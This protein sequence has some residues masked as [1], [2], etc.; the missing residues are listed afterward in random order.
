MQVQLIVTNRSRRGEI[1][2]VNVPEFRIGRAEDCH[3]RLDSSWVSPLHCVIQSDNDTVTIQDSSGK[4]GTFV[5]SGRISSSQELKDGDKIRIGELSFVVSIGADADQP[6]TTVKP[7]GMESEQEFESI[8]EI[9]RNH[10]IVSLTKSQLF[11]LAQAGEVLPDDVVTVGGTKA[12]AD[13][14]SGIVFGSGSS[15]VA[16]P[17]VSE[18]QKSE[19]FESYPLEKKGIGVPF[20][21]TSKSRHQSQRKTE[22]NSVEESSPFD[23]AAEPC[24][25]IDRVP[26][27]NLEITYTK[28]RRSLYEPLSQAST[29]FDETTSH[30]IKIGG[31]VFAVLFLLGIVIWLVSGGGSEHRAVPIAGTVTL[32]GMPVHMVNVTLYPRAEDGLVAGGMT[33]RNGRFRVRTGNDTRHFGAVPGEYDV[34]F[35]GNGVPGKYGGTETSGQFLVVEMNGNRT[36]EFNLDSEPAIMLPRPQPALPPSTPPRL[37]PVLPELTQGTATRERQQLPY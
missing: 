18:T 8:F 23:I 4:K 15:A 27:A 13:S 36:F 2:P 14:I 9:R 17:T 25:Q 20:A 11:E 12:F 7:S 30:Q 1:I 3:F 22:K 26:G 19:P 21:E 10:R 37:A 31:S 5:N 32:D 6:E 24:V 29:W 35:R 34:T 33:D 28:P 16:S